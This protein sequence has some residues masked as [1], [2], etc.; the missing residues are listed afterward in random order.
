M[1]TEEL[2]AINIENDRYRNQVIVPIASINKSSIR[3]LRYAKTISDNVIAFNVSI[4]EE[5]AG[6]IRER[7]NMLNTDIPLII[8]Y[9]P[10][11]KVVEPLLKFIES[12]E[13]DYNRG[14]MITVILPQFSVKSWWHN[15]LH[16]QTIMFVRR[17]LLRHKHIV[18]AIM[19]L[20]LRDDDYVLKNPKYKDR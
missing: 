10:F 7:Y 19:P 1:K 11:R 5:S 17:E 6:K 20:Q 15:L 9:S 2:K 8:K 14:D 13:Y 16:N 4:D 3:A 18:V 12:T